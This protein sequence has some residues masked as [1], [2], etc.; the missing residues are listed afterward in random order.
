VR[1]RQAVVS[2]EAYATLR[3]GRDYAWGPQFK[4]RYVHVD[5]NVVPRRAEFTET[6]NLP[7][8]SPAQD[9]LQVELHERGLLSSD[10]FGSVEH[11]VASFTNGTP[12]QLT[13]N[14]RNMSAVVTVVA[15]GFGVQAPI[16][17]VVQ[18]TT[19][20]MAPQPQAQV[21][22]TTPGP[23]P[24][25]AVDPY[26]NPYQMQSPQQTQMQPQPVY[27]APQQQVYGAPPPYGQPQQQMYAPQPVYVQQS[28][29]APPPQ[30]TVTTTYTTQQ[31]QV[32]VS[33]SSQRDNNRA[34]KVNLDINPFKGPAPT[35]F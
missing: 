25:Y 28:Y 33:S 5:H 7:V 16:Q 3:V 32:V 10:I 22:V 21:Y 9:V 34:G 12:T 23:A 20:Q 11:S 14:G 2:S 27:G 29:A 24:A 19:Y 31:P 17:Q 1:L 13:I 4:T 35:L 26:G 6:F 30:Q 15:N 18:Q 8:K